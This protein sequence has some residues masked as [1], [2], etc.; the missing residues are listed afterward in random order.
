[1][2]YAMIIIVPL[3]LLAVGICG[4][5]QYQDNTGHSAQ[6]TVPEI[7]TGSGAEA[8]A[9]SETGVN[10]GAGAL[11]TANIEPTA[12]PLLPLDLNTILDTTSTVPL[13][14]IP[15]SYTVLVS[16]DYLLPADYIPK[17]LAEPNV[18]FSYN[19]HLE[20]RKMHITAAK[21]L[22]K[23]FHAAEAKGIILYGVSGYRSYQRQQGIYNRNVALHGKKATDSLSAK[24][25]S[26]EHQSGLA[27]DVSASSVNCLLTERL[28]DTKE[29]KWLA[30]N[31]HKYGYIVRYPK[32]KTK[33]TGYSYE[34]W[35]IRYVGV[36]VATY[37]YEHDLTLEEYYGV[38]NK[39]ETKSGVDVEDPKD[40]ATATP[41]T[42]P[43][44][45]PTASVEQ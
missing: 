36:P 27:I 12:D 33:I 14:T 30:K 38:S 15:D 18:R 11:A 34:P 16:R 43:S 1:M 5:I 21:A 20:K 25:G 40:Y 7:T 13:D 28:A 17:E 10:T 23:M 32:G 9:E 24:P 41:S 4:Y 29:G 2:K 8:T 31:C 22:E 35:H 44:A 42:A 19:E 39:S 37:L 3:L 26:S 6:T 45:T